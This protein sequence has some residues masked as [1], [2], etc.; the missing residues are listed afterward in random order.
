MKLFRKNHDDR[1]CDTDPRL[2]ESVRDLVRRWDPF[3]V[4]LTAAY[5]SDRPM[6]VRDLIDVGAR[7][8]TF[9][10][11]ES[12]R[13]LAERFTDQEGT[14]RGAVDEVTGMLDDQPPGIE[15]DTADLPSATD[16]AARVGEY[17]SS[18]GDGL[19][20]ETADSKS[21]YA[22][23]LEALRQNVVF[24]RAGEVDDSSHDDES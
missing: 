7:P 9:G 24:R 21:L 4:A 5:L 1:L 8:I 3:V 17:L 19:V 6:T 15:E 11:D 13:E 22:R 10:Y 12:N 2:V 14:R 18:F 20:D 23:D 16:A